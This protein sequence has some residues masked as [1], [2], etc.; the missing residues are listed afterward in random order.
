M[1]VRFYNFAKKTNSTAQP[2]GSPLAEFDCILKDDCSVLSPV[3]ALEAGLISRPAF[4][5]AYIPDFQR[6]YFINDWTFSRRLWGCSMT[7]DTLAS[8][9]T[10]I[11]SKSLYILRSSAQSNGRIVDSKYPSLC[12]PSSYIDDIGTVYEEYTPQGSDTP[13]QYA[14]ANYFSRTLTQGY[15][16]FGVVGANG[17]G[18]TWYCMSPGS[19]N[20]LVQAL[21]AYDP[22][23]MP[24]WDVGVRK[25]LANPM[26]YIVACYWLPTDILGLTFETKTINFGL[27]PV[28]VNTCAEV[29]PVKDIRRYHAD[30]PI[31]KH[32]QASTRGLYLNQGPFTN[33]KIVMAPWGS[34]DL[35]STLMIDDQTATANWY[36]DYTTG[37]ADLT[38]KV[39]NSYMV[40]TSTML[41]IPIRLTQMTVDNLAG[42]SQIVEGVMGMGAALM[43]GNILGAVGGVAAA[44]LGGFQNSIASKKPSVN[45]MGGGG[46]FVPFNSFVPKIYSDFYR[47]ADEYNA[48]IGRP[49]CTVSTPATLGG[50]MIA[51]HGDMA[52]AMAMADEID[53]I[54]GYL[55]GGFFYE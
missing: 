9:K 44:T 48:E 6:Y 39:T 20:T 32:P 13:Q 31:R 46:N 51:Q 2:S 36:I 5:Y 3:I 18:T 16:Y 33:Y 23:D 1:L 7:V 41:G 55:T 24:S 43:T 19:F 54:N 50:Y 45:T 21:Y 15:Y 10:E 12:Q 34:F 4:N 25:Q 22:N 8:W 35:D 27:Y 42:A 29:D 52:I 47:I 53:M 30:F 40:H 17:T 49:L 28:Q 26:Q 38:I 11:G 37:I 14:R